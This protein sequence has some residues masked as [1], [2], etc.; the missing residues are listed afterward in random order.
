M[1][2]KTC[3]QCDYFNSTQSLC[4]AEDWEV[5]ANDECCPLFEDYETD[6]DSGV[7]SLCELI[8]VHEEFCTWPKFA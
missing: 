7:K 4:N 3:S 1:A 5:H 6:S 8:P 2:I